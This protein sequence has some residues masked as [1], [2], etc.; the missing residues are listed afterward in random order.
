MVSSYKKG[1]DSLKFPILFLKQEKLFFVKLLKFLV[2]SSKL[3]IFSNAEISK[4]ICICVISSNANREKSFFALKI[5]KYFLTSTFF[6]EKNS[7]FLR[8]KLKRR[9]FQINRLL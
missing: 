5:I 9:S 6:N 2:D 8:I 4:R 1:R 3:T 7:S